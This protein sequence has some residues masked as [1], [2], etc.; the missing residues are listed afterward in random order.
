MRNLSIL[1]IGLAFVILH[2]HGLIQQLICRK[3]KFTKNEYF[4]HYKSKIEAKNATAYN[5]YMYSMIGKLINVEKLIFNF[6]DQK[7][8]ILIKAKSLFDTPS[9][10]D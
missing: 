3:T 10:R 7:H 1:H 8:P 2:V 5:K 6:H 4:N 9:T